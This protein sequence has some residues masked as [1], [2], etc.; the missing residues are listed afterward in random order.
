MRK[1]EREIDEKNKSQ[2]GS[3]RYLFQYKKEYNFLSSQ[4]LSSI[5][6]YK[7]SMI[8]KN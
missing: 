2:R 4:A 3:A 5:S 6:S 7:G 8:M 1:N